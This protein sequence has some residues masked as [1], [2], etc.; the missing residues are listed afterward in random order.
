LRRQVPACAIPVYFGRGMIRMDITYND[1]TN[2]VSYCC[3]L[4]RLSDDVF[5]SR[6]LRHAAT[7]VRPKQNTLEYSDRT[8]QNRCYFCGWVRMLLGDTGRLQGA[9]SLG[10]TGGDRETEP[11]RG[12]RDVEQEM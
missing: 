7:C 12:K 1:R 9:W 11:G 4:K 5:I 2:H 8:N 6:A 3:I 10:S